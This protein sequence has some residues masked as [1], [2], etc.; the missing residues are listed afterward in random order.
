MRPG[1]QAF[2]R[3]P[4]QGTRRRYPA[5][6]AALAEG[7]VHLTG[8]NLLAAHLK[9]LTAADVDH[10]LRAATHRSKKDIEL[11]LAQRF[12]KADLQAEV[13]PIPSGVSLAPRPTSG[14]AVHRPEPAQLVAPT[15]GEHAPAQVGDPVILSHQS[16]APPPQTEFARVARLAPQR[17]GVQFTMDQAGHDL[18][19]QVQ[20]LLG[21]E[22]P[23][24][25]LA[26]VFVR[27]L[28]AYAAQLERRKCAATENPHTARR[29]NPDS[30]HVPAHVK[31]FVRKRDKG[32]CTYVSDSGHRCEAR[33]DLEYDHVLE[34]ARGGEATVSNIR[35]RCRAHNQ[36]EAERTYGVE[37]MRHKRERADAE[38][39]SLERG[40]GAGRFCFDLSA[41]TTDT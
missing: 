15:E 35:L 19:L 18:L 20:D 1:V 32:R 14:P 26:E 7:R 10:V 9:H 17:Y 39:R 24:G 2:E 4:D 41:R 16:A 23:R 40:H 13:R 22:V 21:H 36:L 11:L 30:R 33:S 29:R 28:K 6:L 37:F 5:V 8:L 38:R 25:D 31:R 34:Y 27:A 3:R 12:P